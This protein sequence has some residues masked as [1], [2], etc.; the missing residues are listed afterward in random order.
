MLR[1]LLPGSLLLLAA[2]SQSHNPF[3]TEDSLE[4]LPGVLCARWDRCAQSARAPWGVEGCET[5]MRVHL[6]NVVLPRYEE[7][8]MRGT[9]R[10]NDDARA[11]CEMSAAEACTWVALVEFDGGLAGLAGVGVAEP[12][13]CPELLEGLVEIGGECAMDEECAGGAHCRQVSCEG[14]CHGV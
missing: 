1:H 2:C 8:I 12:M 4:W 13:S 14:G 6:E 10:V 7:A 11:S 3:P 9:A 5:W